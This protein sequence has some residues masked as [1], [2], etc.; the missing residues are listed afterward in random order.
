M[1]S[2]IYI[3]KNKLFLQKLR[4]LKFIVGPLAS[5]LPIMLSLTIFLGVLELLGL[6]L[7]IPFLTAI[8]SPDKLSDM[9][10][11]QVLNDFFLLTNFESR[12][13]VLSLIL[14]GVFTFKIV[15]NCFIQNL[16]I[17]FSYKLQASLRERLAI[18]Y[19]RAPYLFHTRK[20]TNDIINTMLGH[21]S[22]FSK[23]IVGSL[24]KVFSEGIVILTISIFLIAKFPITALFSISLIMMFVWFYV[25]KIKGRIAK[26]GSELSSASSELIKTL[27]QGIK[28][29][30][31]ARV[32]GKTE[33]FENHIMVSSNRLSKINAETAFHQILPRFLLEF[34]IISVILIALLTQIMVSGKNTE[35]I[36]NLILFGAASI[37]LLPSINNITVNLNQIYFAAPMTRQI[38]DDLRETGDGAFS[39]EKKATEPL[40][41][42]EFKNLSFQFLG[43]ENKILDKVNF[44][45]K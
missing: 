22:Q 23:G 25:Y 35:I 45:I 24:L 42:L 11:W 9:K 32:L 1:Y 43:S 15:L 16:I 4:E 6:S 30:K 39:V 10:Y 12:V 20:R 44:S 13:I 21:V 5:K 7:I 38:L 2:L 19:M 8:Q 27:N 28:G 17:K 34:L 37:R 36:N 26:L 40:I 41:S 31:E 14:L 3:F 29:L 18:S 33:H